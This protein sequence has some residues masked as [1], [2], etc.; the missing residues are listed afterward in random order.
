[1]RAVAAGFPGEDVRVHQGIGM[2]CSCQIIL[3][4]AGKVK[5][6]LGLYVF[7]AFQQL[8]IAAPAD[9][10]AAEQIRLR[11]RHLEQALWLE[12][13]LRAEDVGVRLEADAGAATIVDLAEILELALGVAAL[14]RHAVELLA[15]RDFD[16]E[17]RREGID[18]GN[19]DAVQP[20]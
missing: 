4:A 13:R 16:F 20:A 6:C 7:D 10:D 12:G 9:F 3:Q 19:A 17:T 14:E 8:G 1:M 11:A 5:R 2:D 18:D 15:A